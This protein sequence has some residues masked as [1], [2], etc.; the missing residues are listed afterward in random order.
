MS[1]TC[2]VCLDLKYSAQRAGNGE[3]PGN[4]NVNVRYLRD[5]VAS[6]GCRVCLFILECLRYFEFELASGD[7]VMLS[8]QE[9]NETTILEPLTYSTVQIYT[10]SGQPPAWQGIVTGRDLSTHPDSQAADDFIE[11]CLAKCEQHPTCRPT[12]TYVP[13]RL[14]DVGLPGNTEVRVVETVPSSQDRYVAL[15]YCWGGLETIKTIASNYEAMKQ[16][17]PISNLPQTIRDAI[18]VTRKLKVRHVWIDALC[19]I[20]D[21]A[22]DWEIESSNMASVYR[23]AYLTISAATAACVTE[24]FLQHEHFAAGQKP[25]L[26]IE[27]ETWTGQRTLLGARMVPAETTHTLDLMDDD[28][29]PL[30]FRGWTLQESNLSTRVLGYHQEELWWSCLGGS[31]CECGMLDRVR[32]KS[33]I[34]SFWPFYS[35]TDSQEAYKDWHEVVTEFT[36][37]VL[38]ISSDKLP[39]ISGIAQVVQD[40]TKSRYIAGVWLDNLVADLSWQACMENDNIEANHT[41]IP[42]VNYGA[43]TFSW[44]SIEHRIFYSPGWVSARSCTV[45]DADCKVAGQN[46]LGPIDSAHVTLRGL[47]LETTLEIGPG[48]M[49]PDKK[50]Y[51]VVHGSKT[52]RP[53]ADMALETFEFTNENG[54]VERSVRRSPPGSS[55]K[56]AE[57]G[58]PVFLFYIGYHCVGRLRKG[59]NRQRVDHAYLLLG[60]SPRDSTKYERIGIVTEGFQ[61]EVGAPEASECS[62]ALEDFSEA[63]VTIL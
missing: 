55:T 21:S 31:A 24:G 45:L 54:V 15:S 60:K 4:S 49:D 41:V 11:S 58:T 52:L 59:G 29:P 14:I 20:Q 42:L 10:P 5:F 61:M 2:D 62:E 39:A 35:I 23:N 50:T 44:A 48:L 7:F 26:I 53:E 38:T 25:P 43:P 34:F 1:Q 17:I 9:N 27:W 37:R 16:G 22:S 18:T 6:R 32:D 46:L 8:M 57:S 40:I 36:S 33:K 12:S 13:T 56:Q 30:W 63:I 51:V 47:R 3:G 19:I 28:T